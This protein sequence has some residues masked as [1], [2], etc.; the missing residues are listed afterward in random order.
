MKRIMQF[1]QMVLTPLFRL[2]YMRFSLSFCYV[3]CQLLLLQSL[4]YAFY[5]HILCFLYF[6]DNQRSHINKYYQKLY[7]AL[8]AKM[9]AQ[10]DMLSLL[11]QPKEGQQQFKNKKQPELTENLT[12][13]KS[14]NQGDKEE[15]FIQIGRRGR[16]G[17]LGRKDLWQG[18]SWQTQG[19]GRLWN[20]MGKAAAGWQG[21]S[22]WTG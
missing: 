11:A 15:T 9:D 19:G 2:Q 1:I 17:Q 5:S 7:F 6:H 22:C 12:V 10:V 13:W 8:L 20:G 16:D 3:Q 18:G 21:S 14:D 4:V